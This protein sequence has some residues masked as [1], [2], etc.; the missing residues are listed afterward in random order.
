MRGLMEDLRCARRG[1]LRRPWLTLAAFLTLALG[2]GA[3]TVIFSVVEAV[4]LHPLPFRDA[5]RI[6]YPMLS[7]VQGG[8]TYRLSPDARMIRAWQA[9]AASFEQIEAYMP[10]E[11][12]LEDDHEKVRA[13]WISAD[14]FPFLGVE[15]VLGRA[16]TA[17]EADSGARVAVLSDALWRGR[18][19][20]DPGVLGQ[21]IRV[22]GVPH[23]ILGVLP[24]QARSIEPRV[25][26]RIWLPLKSALLDSEKNLPD[27]RAV[28]RLRLGA[29]VGAARAELD[30]AIAG[31]P[32]TEGRKALLLKPSDQL[33][34]LPTMVL[35]IQVAVGCVLLI[36]CT[37][38][39]HLALAQG[40]SRAREM[41]MRA[42]LGAGRLRL[43]RQLLVESL[44]LGLA[45]GVL[46][47][48][49]AMWG[50]D[51]LV[52]LLPRSLSHLDRLAIHDEALLFT[53]AVSLV[54]GVL[55]GLVPALR[56]STPSLES[57]LRR[58]TGH[59][60]RRTWSRRGLVA[61]E[62]GLTV[63][64]LAGAGSMINTFVRWQNIGFGFDPDGLTILWIGLDEERFS[65]PAEQVQLA[66]QLVERLQRPLAGR[67]GDPQRPLG[68]RGD[69]HAGLALTNG[70]PFLLADPTFGVPEVEGR[71][72]SEGEPAL[73]PI[74]TAL[75]GYFQT[76]RIPLLEGRTFGEQDRAGSGPVVILN[77]T[78]ARRYWGDESPVGSRMRLQPQEPWLRV[79]GVVADVRQLG[80]TLEAAQPLVYR[81]FRQRPSPSF[82]IAVRSSLAPGPL[83]TEL[84]ALLGD[85]GSPWKLYKVDTIEE[86]VRPLIEDSRFYTLLMTLFASIAAV[87]AC[88][89]IY[90]VIAYSVG[91][92]RREI[93]IRMAVG[94][95]GAT[96]VGQVL[97]RG[98]RPV[99]VGI[100]CGL[101]GATALARVLGSQVHEAIRT[102]DSA[103]F[104]SVAILVAVIATTAV[105]LPA[106]RASRVDPT[107]VLRQE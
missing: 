18:F 4:L 57:A 26:I 54:T 23:T 91:Q 89:G 40:E 36:A 95:R 35:I 99:A 33:G 49:I 25:K 105:W 97:G 11:H 63:A 82:E 79:V 102:W 107:A 2:I 16:F 87:M 27:V 19:G 93:G 41:T 71:P 92:Q 69:I 53:L 14:M 84:Q 6:V 96:V 86:R 32:S 37:N 30:A 68:V 22:D 67:E 60:R 29:D 56:A 52:A 55:F 59:G 64:L 24:P 75:P 8:T 12:R 10:Y 51:A 21:E 61:L 50:L 88:V 20:A 58:G 47:L 17:E 98:L 66:E 62:V 45:G 106:R 103:I 83:R 101:G 73:Y 77:E 9:R 38:V 100:V 70:M 34:T 28:G 3:N 39:A 44:A 80:P 42:V 94:A 15:P 81:P 85:P 74:V 48:L 76:L 78:M 104:G 65:E 1:L 72:D 13:A 43:L 46:G 90:G 7:H 31:L 5:D